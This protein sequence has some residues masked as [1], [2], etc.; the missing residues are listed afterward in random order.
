[1]FQQQ[2]LPPM[3]LGRTRDLTLRRMRSRSESEVRAKLARGAS[4]VEQVLTRHIIRRAGLLPPD[5]EQ[6]VKRN[7]IQGK[8]HTLPDLVSYEYEG[9]EVMA[10]WT[11]VENDVLHI[12]L[13]RSKAPAPERPR[14][15]LRRMVGDVVPWGPRMTGA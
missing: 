7:Q 8:G 9:V 2:L 13:R 4:L 1:M 12:L 6:R 14:A 10:V 5:W 15:R 11:Y 3:V